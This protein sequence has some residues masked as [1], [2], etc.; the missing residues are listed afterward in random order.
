MKNVLII[1]DDP[2][3]AAALE[4]RFRSGGYGTE[5]AGDA[6][7]GLSK[8]VGGQ[9][10]LIVLDIS[11]PG[12]NGLDLAKR[13]KS[14]P[15]TRAAPIIFVTASK[16]PDLRQRAMDLGAAGLF[17]KPYDAAE[18]LAVAGHALGET[19]MFKRPIARFFPGADQLPPATSNS[20]PAQK[21]VLVI[22]DDRRIALALALR[23]QAAGF[24]ATL[25]HDALTGVN[26]AVKSQ[27]DLI[28]LDISMPAGDGFVVA[29]RVHELLSTDTPMIFLTA[30]AQP[31]VREKAMAMGAYGFF[32]KPIETDKLMATIARI[33][34]T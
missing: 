23:L 7:A 5:M 19:G 12:G 26:M 13:F 20:N 11:L 15:E 28:L 1:E 24:E 10:D 18:L 17:E 16:A 32:E 9:P 3:I 27:P 31:G 8:A 30:H 22:E 14:I 4:I 6:I 25:A 21:R 2:N 33:V 34:E 29:S